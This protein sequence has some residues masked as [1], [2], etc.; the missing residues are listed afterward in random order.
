VVWLQALKCRNKSRGPIG[1]R[2]CAMLMKAKAFSV[3]E[4]TLKGAKTGPFGR[5]GGLSGSTA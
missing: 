5:S 3:K 4:L 1:P 2:H